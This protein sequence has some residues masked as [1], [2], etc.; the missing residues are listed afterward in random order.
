MA[1]TMKNIVFWD[2]ELWG[3]VQTRPTRCYIPEDDILQ[4][5]IQSTDNE[6]LESTTLNGLV[7]K[8]QLPHQLMDQ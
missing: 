7:R 1:M 4:R 8:H 2:V 3:S 6:D 5:K